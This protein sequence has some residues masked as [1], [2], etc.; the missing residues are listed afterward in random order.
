MILRE[1]FYRVSPSQETAVIESIA[2][3]VSEITEETTYEPTVTKQEMTVGEAQEVSRR[4][5]LRV[6][7]L[8]VYAS[9]WG[10]GGHLVGDASRRA[11]SEYIRQVRPW[12]SYKYHAC[13]T[14]AR[15][16]QRAPL[17]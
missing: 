11:W 13:V 4:L 5:R 6:F 12:G 3:G 14:V 10:M 9:V 8:C 16:P 17:A 7:L 1:C 2:A 15:P